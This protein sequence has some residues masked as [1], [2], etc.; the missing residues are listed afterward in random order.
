MSKERRRAGHIYR[1][2]SGLRVIGVGEV[3]AM[4]W[5]AQVEKDPLKSL[6]SR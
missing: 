1:A 2:E 6:K 4:S 3:R 5:L